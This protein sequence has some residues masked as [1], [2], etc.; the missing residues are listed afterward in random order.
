MNTGFLLHSINWLLF[1]LET[2]FFDSML[3][4]C[5]YASDFDRL[6]LCEQSLSISCIIVSRRM[7]THSR[8]GLELW[9]DCYDIFLESL[10][11]INDRWCQVKRRK[12]CHEFR[13][14]LV[15]ENACFNRQAFFRATLWANGDIYQKSATWVFSRTG[16]SSFPHDDFFRKWGIVGHFHGSLNTFF[17]VASNKAIEFCLYFYFLFLI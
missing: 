11:M 17:S 13:F 8:E 16:L 10:K 4:L 7:H 6:F 1:L 5:F 15:T 3:I 9:G 14:Q 2:Y 12:T